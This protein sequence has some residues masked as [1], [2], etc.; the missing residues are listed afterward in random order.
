MRLAS[1]EPFVAPRNPA[2]GEQPRDTFR[3]APGMHTDVTS[4]ELSANADLSDWRVLLRRVESRY[5]ATSFPA[6]AAFINSIADAAETARHHPDIDLRYPGV[7]HVAIT[8][9]ATR[10]LTDADVDLARTISALATA[11]GL[12]AE[13]PTGSTMEIAIDAM[14][15]NA[16]RPFWAAVLGYAEGRPSPSGAP[17]DEVVDPLRIGPSIW[18]Q[19]MDAERPQRNRVH[20]DVTVAH[21]EA[22]AR[23]AAAIAAGGRLVS[24]EHARAFWVLADAEGNEACV[25]TWQDRT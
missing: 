25:C 10:G 15:I 21:D 16:I 17:S 14:D 1:R 18:F 3:Y 19:Q 22:D 2:W 7:V 13:P 5:R 9:H 23:V 20:L 6:A 24:D 11:A 8:T 4:A 12:T